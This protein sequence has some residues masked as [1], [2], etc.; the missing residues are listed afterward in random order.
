LSFAETPLNAISRFTWSPEASEARP[1]LKAPPEESSSFRVD[2]EQSTSNKKTLMKYGENYLIA[3]STPTLTQSGLLAVLLHSP[4]FLFTLAAITGTLGFL[5]GLWF[6][7]PTH[8]APRPSYP[9]Y[10]T[11]KSV[12]PWSEP[13]PLEGNR[14]KGGE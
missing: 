13:M 10:D 8:H 9:Y 6:G 3:K 1:L 5:F 2:L 11:Q 4:P 7:I 14:D 12:P